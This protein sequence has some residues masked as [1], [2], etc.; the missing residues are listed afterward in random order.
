MIAALLLAALQAAP[1]AAQPEL[2]RLDH[3]QRIAAP[4]AAVWHALTT[5][6][7]LRWIAPQSRVELRVGGAYELYF[8]PDNADDRGMEG[9]RV[10]A[11]V[12][13]SMLATSGEIE[14]SWVVWRLE[15]VAD[16]TLVHISS[17]GS[18]PAWAERAPYFDA[19]MP[20][21]LSRLAAAVE[22]RRREAR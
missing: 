2:L 6:E 18:G 16:G 17:L 8:W 21:V 12:P 9:T 3:Q 1:A 14:G 4:P 15:P 5:P 19:A 11:F 13:G 10:L 22:A 20:G 7:G